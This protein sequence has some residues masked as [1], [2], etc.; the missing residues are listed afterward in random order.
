MAE[1]GRDEAE[2]RVWCPSA[3]ASWRDYMLPEICCAMVVRPEV[4]DP[5]HEL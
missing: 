4:D 3:A 1:S 5:S 2:R